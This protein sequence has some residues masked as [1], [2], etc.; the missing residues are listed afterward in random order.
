MECSPVATR[1]RS[2]TTL[3]E[4]FTSATGDQ[5]PII[6]AVRTNCFQMTRQK[7]GELG[8]SGRLIRAWPGGPG[9]ARLDPSW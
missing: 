4:S 5:K 1:A 6:D 7:R 8:V 2:W 9:E 3:R